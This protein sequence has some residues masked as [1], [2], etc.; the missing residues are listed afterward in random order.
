MLVA[1]ILQGEGKVRV[2]E[3]R[4]AADEAA[5][6]L[7]FCNEYVPAKNPADYLG[8][9]TGWSSYTSSTEGY[10]WSYNYDTSG[11]VEVA[12]PVTTEGDVRTKP[13]QKP[14]DLLIYYGYPNSFNYNVNA[15][16]NEKVAQ[17]MAKYSMIVLGNGLADKY[18]S[19]SH[20]G[21][22]DQ[23]I[24]TDSTKAWTVDEHVGKAVRNLTDGSKG[25]I[26]AN[27]ATTITAVLAGGAENDWDTGDIYDVRHIDYENMLII[28]ARLKELKPNIEIFGYVATTEVFADFKAKVDEWCDIDVYGVFV[29]SAGYDY[30]TPATNGRDAF[31]DR[32]NYIH[33]KACT[34]IV[35]VNAW[36]TDHILGTVNDPL[37]PN[38]TWNPS[39]VESNLGQYDW[40]L[41]ESFPINTTAWGEGYEAKAEWLE[42]GNK[43]I[44]QRETYGVNLAGIGII[45]NGRAD[46]QDLF[47]FGFISALMWNIAVFGTSDTSYGSGSSEVDW[48]TRPD[49]EG[50][51]CIWCLDPSIQED[52][53]D[54][55]VYLRFIEYGKLLLDFS[56][57]AQDSSITKW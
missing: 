13:Y 6:V 1:I 39:V 41:M 26:T 11:L 27:T 52:G 8:Y 25:T 46:G 35:F 7:A 48:W 56:A 16:D 43:I 42:R 24:L 19:G 14:D 51:G 33:N 38:T 3:F 29:D 31:N 23:A 57:S 36:N 10:Y 5:A 47:D 9:N 2:Q 30:G 21:A 50:L 49:S 17:D 4:E 40:V 54:A 28:I 53:N 32:I 20:T 34:N 55:D 37:Y 15:W 12:I 45:N 22:D 18:A 44:A